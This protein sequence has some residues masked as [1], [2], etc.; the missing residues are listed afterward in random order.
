MGRSKPQSLTL[1]SSRKARNEQAAARILLVMAGVVLVYAIIAG[2]LI[3]YGF[4]DPKTGSIHRLADRSTSA[5]RPELVDRNGETLAMDIKMASLFAE[6]HII[7]DADEAI[8]LLST[9]L[10]DIEFKS[11]HKKLTSK[12]KFVWLKRELT[13]KQ[14]SRILALGI[15]GIGFRTENRRFYPGG[16]T[17]AHILG[18]VNVD[19][20]G[21]SGIEKYVDDNGLADLH[22]AGFARKREL[23][24]VKL[25][26]DLRVQH[27]IR[28]ALSEAMKRYKAVA[29]AGIVLNAHTGEIVGM[30][31]LPD[32]N[33]NEKTDLRKEK[34]KF[35]R[36][37][38]GVF[39]MGSTFKA[40]TTAMALDSGKVSL[41]SRFDAR[42]PIRIGRFRIND[43]HGKKRILSVPEVFIYSSNIGTAKMADVV[44][45][46]GH[47]EFLTRIGLLSRLEGFELPEVARPT[48]PK[49]WKKVNSITISY[50]H[51]ISTTPLQTAAAA[52]ALVN[53]GMLIPPT[54]FPRTRDEAQRLG[55]QVVSSATSDKMRYLMRLNVLK[56]SGKRANV[57]GFRVGGKTGTAEKVVN[58]RYS[59]AKRFNA[60]LSA[61]PVDDPQ[62]VVLVIVDEPKPEEGKYYATAGMNAAPTV[63]RIVER[64]APLLGVDPTFEPAANAILSS[65]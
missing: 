54:L 1:S 23:E 38:G 50:G 31:S 59:R 13:P 10:P 39:E 4:S 64:S 57:E 8:E 16:P 34:D 35:N 62:Y 44:G 28:D 32:Y 52:A 19:N 56:G 65:Y 46:D 53:G 22:A 15:P 27:F 7:V 6:P 37:S 20:V 12:A 24:P 33:P 11:V 55:K 25:A 36:I 61:F 3:Y 21:I 5:T 47:Q 18:Q 45:I 30:S 60:F 17:A 63:A 41:K 51:G 9:V 48:Q 43:F 49:V 26:V 14:Q 40:F 29:A 58:G 42:K 2:R